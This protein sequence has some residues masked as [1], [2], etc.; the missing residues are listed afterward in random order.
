MISTMTRIDPDDYLVDSNILVYSVDVA[1]VAKQAR[2]INTIEQL[3]QHQLGIL[4]A[5]C[6]TEFFR[7]A[8]RKIQPPLSP[9][10]A[11]D[12]VALFAESFRVLDIT[13]D[14]VLEA[15]RAASRYQMSIWDALI[16][17]AAKVN[18]VRYILTED[19]QLRPAIEGVLYVDPLCPEFDLSQLLPSGSD[20]ANDE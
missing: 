8:T 13:L 19:V 18:D 10:S 17:S 15:C 12:H 6:L 5:Q 4:S 2:A 1:D 20:L 7:A 3:R 9:E 14:V 16:W 11:A